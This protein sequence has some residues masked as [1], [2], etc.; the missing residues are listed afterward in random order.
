MTRGIPIMIVFVILLSGCARKAEESLVSP[1]Y[2]ET[3]TAAPSSKQSKEVP[4][5]LGENMLTNTFGFADNEGKFIVTI[6]PPTVNSDSVEE[7]NKAIGDDGQVLFIKYV[8]HQLKTDQDNGRQTANNFN[9]VEG[10]LF[11]VVEGTASPD[12][13]YYLVND[14]MFNIQSLLKIRPVEPQ[15]PPALIKDEIM[16]AR[17][18]TIDHSWLIAE[19]GEESQIFLVQYERQEDRM[20]ACL[21]VKAGDKWIFMDYPANYDEISTWR[22]DDQGE[23]SPDMFSFL[24]AARSASGIILGVKWMGAEGEDINVIKQSASRFVE[25]DIGSGRYMSPI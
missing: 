24:F 25:T 8:K 14:R 12:G 23:I 1:A 16:K 22:V 9:H 5:Q 4:A 6:E 18:R 2:S 21:V 7:M 20:L 19:V 15:D 11:E 3:L 17:N 10:D 13:S